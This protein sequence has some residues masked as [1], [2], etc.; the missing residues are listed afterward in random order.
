M[1]RIEMKKCK[2]CG[3][4][5]TWKS[6]GIVPNPKDFMDYGMCAVCR[7]RNAKGTIKK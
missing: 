6:G 2:S 3:K 1:L 4:I 5:Y 7:A